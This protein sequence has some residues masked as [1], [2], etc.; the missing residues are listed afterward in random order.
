MPVPTATPPPVPLCG[1]CG[2]LDTPETVGRMAAMLRPRRAPLGPTKLRK[3]LVAQALLVT[4]MAACSGTPG[5]AAT[6]TPAA[7]SPSPPI[8]ATERSATEIGDPAGEM[9]PSPQPTEPPVGYAAAE[10]EVPG[11]SAIRHT[12]EPG[13]TLLGLAK[14]YGV[15]MAAIQL[16][17]QMGEST[18]VR[19]GQT[20]SIPSPTDA[21]WEGSS[22]FW[23]V[24]E[25]KAGET[26][27]AIARSFGVD[28]VRLQAVNQVADADR[29]TA[30]QN[31]VLPLSGP[32]SAQ[33]ARATQAPVPAATSTPPSTA[34]T[35]ES[36]APTVVTQP[37]AAPLVPP[38]DLS[39]W[40]REIAQL[41][42]EVRAQHGIAPLT[43]Q[44]ALGQAAQIQ[45][46][47]CA[48]R[49]WCS[50]TGSDGSDI[51]S[52]ILRTGYQ[53]STWAECWAQ[54]QSPQRAVEVWMNETPPNDPHRRTLLSTRFSEIGI[55]VADATWGAYIIAK[56]GR[57]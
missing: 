44:P 2:R 55:G 34:E 24:H 4:L 12:V 50:H 41:I 56:F 57:P 19:A 7:P 39:D 42:N 1:L 11:G 52:R 16:D 40:A 20:L 29:L 51:R 32:V 45:A 47:D 6:S 46:D 26:L 37:T 53:P 13:D 3:I 48:Q 14:T 22:P 21:V 28:P 54:T 18:V 35:S 8:S 17:N 27:I 15:P 25:V 43:Y 10:G 36:P 5:P 31:L 38:A 49:G 30:G 23:V 33:A 9:E